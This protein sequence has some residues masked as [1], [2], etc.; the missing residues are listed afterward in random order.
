VTES[1]QAPLEDLSKEWSKSRVAGQNTPSSRLPSCQRLTMFLCLELCRWKE[2]ARLLPGRTESA[3]KNHVS[4]VPSVPTPP[5]PRSAQNPLAKASLE[6]VAPG[7]LRCSVL[8]AQLSPLLY[9][10]P[11][12]TANVAARSSLRFAALQWN[13]TLRQKTHPSRC[14]V[15]KQYINSLTSPNV[16]GLC[17]SKSCDA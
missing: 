9:I 3:V 16:G 12:Q 10:L 1:K 15:L 8:G 6:L 17:G 14:S 13:S 11:L 5:L 4:V 2:I 7:R